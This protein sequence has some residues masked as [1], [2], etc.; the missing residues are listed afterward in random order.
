MSVDQIANALDAALRGAAGKLSFGGDFPSTL[1]IGQ[2]IKGR[3][4][5]QYDGHRYLV[6]FSG[7]EKVVDSSIPLKTDEVIQGRVVGLGDRVELQRVYQHDGQASTEPQGQKANPQPLFADKLQAQ[8]ENLIARF[9]GNL[10]PDEIA[11]VVRA[12]R[13][14]VAVDWTAMAGLALSKLGLGVAPELLRAIVKTVED[15]NRTGLFL[16]AGGLDVQTQA[17]KTG[18]VDTATVSK[19]AQSL[20][21]ALDDPK[22]KDDGRPEAAEHGD[23]QMDGRSPSV[24]IAMTPVGQQSGGTSDERPRDWARWILNAQ[25]EGAVLHRIGTFP[26]RLNDQV[27]E[28]DVAA[29]EQR[30]SQAHQEPRHRQIALQLKL[31]GL[32]R[33]D[34][35]AK[36]VDRHVRLTL[37]AATGE[38][39]E[40]LARYMGSLRGTLSEFGWQVDELTYETGEAASNPARKVVE[41]VIAQDSLNRLM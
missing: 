21:Q 5:R 23:P 2:I 6:E 37:G 9:N 33:V 3:V 19:I 18:F 22:T 10:N 8:I 40:T 26:V 15:P 16:A 1:T 11:T 32:G 28:I 30:Q 27:V 34:I 38:S 7:Q 17:A 35:L 25:T 4:L 13:G 20:A 29:F 14:S 12:S 41:H 24:S 36:T 31:A 39:T